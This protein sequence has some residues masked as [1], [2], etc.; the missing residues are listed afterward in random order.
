M[1]GVLFSS[2]S[3]IDGLVRIM[4]VFL[5]GWVHFTCDT[6]ACAPHVTP[7]PFFYLFLFF[8]LFCFFCFFFPCS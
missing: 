4:F 8:L 1:G 7:P 2:C 5:L 6:A 3:D